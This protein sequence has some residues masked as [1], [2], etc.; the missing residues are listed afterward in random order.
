MKQKARRVS[1]HHATNPNPIMQLSEAVEGYIE[2]SAAGTN[3]SLEMIQSEL[4]EMK[5]LFGKVVQLLADNNAIQRHDLQ[6]LLLPYYEMV[7]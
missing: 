5:A 1:W 4:K 6:Y 2:D 7:D 3:G